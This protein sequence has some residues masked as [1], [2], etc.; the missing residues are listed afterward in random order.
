MTTIT[1]KRMESNGEG[2]EPSSSLMD[3]NTKAKLKMV[4]LM[5]EVK[6]LSLMEMST[7]ETGKKA[8]PTAKECFATTREAYTRESGSMISSTERGLNT[9]T[10]TKSSTR[11]ISLKAR[12]PEKELL[13]LKGASMR[14]ILPMANFMVLGSI[15]SQTQERFTQVNSEKTSFMGKA[16]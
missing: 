14:E 6:S 1:P 2:L 16:P 8:K 3:P 4:C 7:S 11:A 5:E 12:R 9:G 13:N 15:I 10:L